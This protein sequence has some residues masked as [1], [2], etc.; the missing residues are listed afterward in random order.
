MYKKALYLFLDESGNFDFSRKGTKYFSI[1][2]ITTQRPFLINQEIEQ[3][4]YN[5]M[6]YGLST[7]YF[8]CADDNK[9]IRENFFKI[10][11][12]HLADLNI[13]SIVIEKNKVSQEKSN[14]FVFYPQNLSFLLKHIIER[15]NKD[16]IEEIIAITDHIPLNKKRKAI[17]KA[18][19]LGLADLLPKNMCYRLLHHASKAHYLLQVVDYCNWA[20]FR[21]WEQQDAYFYNKIKQNI[22]SELLLNAEDDLIQRSE[23]NEEATSST[24]YH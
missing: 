7:E 21:K 18:I 24:I 14:D 11:Q 9:H 8:H 23:T 2:C 13:D 22:K 15:E 20:I 3:Y 5:C 4:K 16:H 19:K 12:K 6:E 1:S 10:I 17:E